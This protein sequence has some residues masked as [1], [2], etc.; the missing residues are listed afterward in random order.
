[1]RKFFIA[2]LVI[3]V[4]ITSSSCIKKGQISEKSAASGH[5]EAV[6]DRENA[7]KPAD[8]APGAEE[9][10]VTDNGEIAARKPLIDGVSISVAVDNSID[11]DTMD[12]PPCSMS[13]YLSTIDSYNKLGAEYEPKTKCA[14]C[15][16]KAVF[17]EIDK[18][19]KKVRIGIKIEKIYESTNNVSGSEFIKENGEINV[20]C[21]YE[22]VSDTEIAFV[23]TPFSG[24]PIT[25]RGA[26]YIAFVKEYVNE[27]TGVL[28]VSADAMTVPFNGNS[29][30]EEEMQYYFSQNYGAWSHDELCRETVQKYLNDEL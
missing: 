18:A 29:V 8:S 4:T 26:E 25:E 17:A 23:V 2:I 9:Q 28:T 5:N 30:G 16:V 11:Y 22:P 27:K 21:G 10:T 14:I 24:M 7:E 3:A 1:M 12:F 20:S 13:R 6:S 15:R 19:E